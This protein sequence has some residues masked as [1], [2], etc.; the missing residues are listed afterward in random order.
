MSS[1]NDSSI[2]LALAY[3]YGDVAYKCQRQW[4]NIK[5]PFVRVTEG[6]KQ[7]GKGL[8]KAKNFGNGLHLIGEGFKHIFGITAIQKRDRSIDRAIAAYPSDVPVDVVRQL[9]KNQLGYQAN[10]LIT[11][12]G[13]DVSKQSIFTPAMIARI[14]QQTMTHHLVGVQPMEGPIGRTYAL[15]MRPDEPVLE[16]HSSRVRLE[17]VSY[18]VAAGSRNLRAHFRPEDMQDLATILDCK[19]LQDAFAQALSSDIASDLDQYVMKNLYDLAEDMGNFTPARDPSLAVMLNYMANDIHR[20]TRRGAANFVVLS[21]MA[22][23]YLMASA[24]TA[25]VPTTISGAHA[26]IRFIGTLNGTMKVFLNPFTDVDVLVGY[27]GADSGL[28]AGAFNCPYIPI[29]SRGVFVDPETFEPQAIFATREGFQYRVDH[30]R[31]YFAKLQL[32]NP[33]ELPT[34]VESKNVTAD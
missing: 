12:N 8:V 13:K 18:A 7:I 15:E 30:A 34:E 31:K 32:N 24:G 6:L 21:P 1:N 27:K 26:A 14:Y 4:K 16:G 2:V 19:D 9:I 11:S 17:I 5:K 20:K 28:D 3:I 33:F 29:I 22:A 25:F 23:T 10:V